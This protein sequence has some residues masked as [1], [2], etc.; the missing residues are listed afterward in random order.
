VTVKTIRSTLI[1]GIVLLI[2]VAVALLGLL[3]SRAD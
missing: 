1:I 3:G 2:A